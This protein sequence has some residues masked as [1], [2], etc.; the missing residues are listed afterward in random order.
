MMLIGG[1]VRMIVIGGPL[2]QPH[3]RHQ[4]Y[5]AGINTNSVQVM[6]SFVDFRT[7]LQALDL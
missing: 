1:P 7:I 2:R 5:P 3:L 4:C 6:H